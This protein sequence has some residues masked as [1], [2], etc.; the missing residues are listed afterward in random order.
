MPEFESYYN[1]YIRRNVLNHE[2]NLFH[3]EGSIVDNNEQRNFIFDLI[4]N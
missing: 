2:D 4:H 1:H 3:L